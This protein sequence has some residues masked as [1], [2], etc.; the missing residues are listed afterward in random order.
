[1]SNEAHVEMGQTDR[2]NSRAVLKFVPFQG[3]GL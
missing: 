1:M 3:I 2:K